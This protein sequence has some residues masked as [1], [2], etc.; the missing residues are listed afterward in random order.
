MTLKSKISTLFH[1]PIIIKD[2]FQAKSPEEIRTK[3]KTLR[4]R[5][6]KLQNEKEI[7][8]YISHLKRN[9]PFTIDKNNNL[10]LNRLS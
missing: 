5:Q 2:V 9:S 4:E 6:I 1:H 7:N 10:M 3:L 8:N